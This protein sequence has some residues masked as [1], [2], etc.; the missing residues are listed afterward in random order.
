MSVSR[1]VFFV[2]VLA[3]A[4]LAEVRF[5]E[6]DEA[7]YRKAAGGSLA[8]LQGEGGCVASS[9]DAGCAD[10]RALDNAFHL[11]VSP[12][13]TSVYVT[14][15][16]PAAEAVAI[17][18]RDGS[19]GAL[20]QLDDG[21]G[22]IGDGAEGC[23]HGRALQGPHD[24]AVSP[25]GQSVY[26][27]A[28]FV[29]SIGS[30]GVAVFARDLSTGTL[31]QL[32]GEDGCVDNNGED[33]CARGRAIEAA[34]GVA[35]SPDGRNVYVASLGDPWAVAVFAR[36]GR[37][38]AL[39]QLRGRDGCVSSNR[40][41]G[42]AGGRAL[43]APQDVAVSPDGENVYVAASQGVAVFAR[44]RRTG[45]LTQLYGKDGCV[46]NEGADGCADGRALGE[47][48][49]VA[50]SPDGSNVYVAAEAVAVF[51]RDR[52]TGALTQLRGRRGCVNNDG[53]GRCTDG[54][55]LAVANDVA[56][57]SDGRSVYVATLQGVAVFAR[58][59]RR[60]TLTQLEGEDGCVDGGGDEGCA[61]GRALDFVTGVAASPDGE[62]VYVASGIS[63]AVA[64]FARR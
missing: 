57:S 55:A 16:G 61:D 51:D 6:A 40:G 29:A 12:D 7:I 48:V 17:F 28:T 56:V 38:G 36:D 8:Q 26:V 35:V 10:G 31:T 21:N 18:A 4:L 19:A 23:T 1:G 3:S 59:R 43:E 11:A 58:N 50:V 30:G 37:T 32:D 41:E 49:S 60:G 2:S 44:D 13:D 46:H 39:A 34:R 62:S 14:S 5:V 45:A 22:C 53:E 54:R 63:D 64:A 24:V 20:T 25:D 27:T 33:G 52:R 15:P 42:C 47:G 9:G